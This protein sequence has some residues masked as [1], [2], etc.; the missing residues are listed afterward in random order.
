M[1]AT[2]MTDFWPSR[3]GW[4][5]KLITWIVILECIENMSDTLYIIF[6]SIIPTFGW[7]H[8]LKGIIWPLIWGD[9]VRMQVNKI[10]FLNRYRS[11][12]RGGVKKKIRKNLGLSPKGG[13]GGLTPAQ[14]CLSYFRFFFLHWNAKYFGVGVILGEKITSSKNGQN[15][16]LGWYRDPKKNLLRVVPNQGGGGG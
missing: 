7:V 2:I 9:P 14:I 10:H 1:Q 6:R 3:T 12:I 11:T 5:I 15:N 8:F 4:T 16:I 13:G